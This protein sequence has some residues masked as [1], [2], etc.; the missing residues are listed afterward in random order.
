MKN[1][2]TSLINDT[3]TMNFLLIDDDKEFQKNL[4]D[5]LENFTDNIS[6]ASDGEEGVPWENGI[7]STLRE[8]HHS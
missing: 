7:Y 8:F 2:V 1:L 5:L 6:I 3:S 4:F